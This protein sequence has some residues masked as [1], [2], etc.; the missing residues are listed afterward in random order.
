MRRRF[1]LVA[2]LLAT[3]GFVAVGYVFLRTMAP[4]ERT[5]ASR[6]SV[7]IPNLSPGQFAYVSN[8]LSTNQ[9][10]SEYLFVRSSDDTLKVF[11]VPTTN[12]RFTMPDRAW[13]RPGHLCRAFEPDFSSKQFQCLDPLAPAWVRK[14]FRWSLDGKSLA[15][16]L[17]E[18]MLTVQGRISGGEFIIGAAP[19]A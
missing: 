1:T 4:S 14:R 3:V 5:E 2:G 7:R 19:E 13:W 12:G 16:E 18:D 11:E 8:P 6:P 15:P 9:W 17:V 10:S